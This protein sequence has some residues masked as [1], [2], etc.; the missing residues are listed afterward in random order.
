MTSSLPSPPPSVA[1]VILNWNAENYLAGCLR[2]VE[3]LDYPNFEIIVVDNASTD[4][5]I[6]LLQQQFP[7]I[8]T[9]QNPTNAG[10]SVGNNVVLRDVAADFVL[11]INPDIIVSKKLLHELISAM[12][13]EPQIGVAGCKLTYPDSNVLQHAGGFLSAPLALPNH[14]G[15]REEDSGQ[16]DEQRDVD[17]VIGAAFAV[18]KEVLQTV[19]LLD[20]G[21]FLYFEEVDFCTRA[22]RAGYRV[23]YVP[24]ATAVHEESVTISQESDAYLQTMYISR[25]R[26]LLKHFSFSYLHNQTIPAE[27]IRLEKATQKHQRAAAFAYRT[28]LRQFA[29]IEAARLRDGMPPFLETEQADLRASLKKL[30]MAARGRADWQSLAN[31][32]EVVERPFTSHIPIIGSLVSALRTLWNNIGTTDYVRPLLEQQNA[33][34]QAIV[35]QIK[36]DAARILAHDEL[37]LQQIEESAQLSAEIKRFYA[38]SQSIEQRLSR[39]LAN[40]GPKSE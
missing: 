27:Q 40:K 32:G 7:H 37:Q 10:Y 26:Y 13:A 25:W 22:K 20:E 5:S 15:L 11:I 33:L 34:N 8:K 35:A 21:Y 4:N 36:A 1:I 30:H 14:F 29:A 38:L 17:Y 24:T 39:L 2:A 23:V 6:Q 31:V 19:G 3:Q 28:T 18:R 9:V 16:F 12:L